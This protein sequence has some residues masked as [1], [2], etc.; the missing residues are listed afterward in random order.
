MKQLALPLTLFFIAFIVF[1]LGLA[2]G[3]SYNP[4]YGSLLWILAAAIGGSG[5][6]SLLR[7]REE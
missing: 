6:V 4:T 3:L 2:V 1:Y 7:R 5:F